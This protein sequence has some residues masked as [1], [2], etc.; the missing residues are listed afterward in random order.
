[1][2]VSR[3]VKHKAGEATNLYPL[4]DYCKYVPLNDESFIF[5]FV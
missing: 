3:C 2:K 4:V 5:H 1:V